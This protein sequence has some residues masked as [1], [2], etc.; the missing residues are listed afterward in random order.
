M[1]KFGTLVDWGIFPF[2]EYPFGVKIE[3]ESLFGVLA[4]VQWQ[5]GPD[6]LKLTYNSRSNEQ[7]VGSC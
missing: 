1:L 5:I 6:V 4:L 7:F 2:I 3:P